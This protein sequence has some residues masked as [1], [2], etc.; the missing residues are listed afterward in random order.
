MDDANALELLNNSLQFGCEW[1]KISDG[2]KCGKK[3]LENSKSFYCK[4]HQEIIERK[5]LP[6][7]CLKCKTKVIYNK[8]GI[9]TLCGYA[10]EI[11]KVENYG[12][13]NQCNFIKIRGGKRCPLKASKSNFYC[14]HH[15]KTVREKGEPKICK[16]CNVARVYNKIGICRKCNY[17]NEIKRYY[18][19]NP[20][21]SDLSA[22]CLD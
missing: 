18:K 7:L 22:I 16:K 8:T 9:C 4:I 17:N 11:K 5:G 13:E 10:K 14:Y 19:S 20:I 2:K 12:E 3:L 1:I 6:K 15:S 21:P